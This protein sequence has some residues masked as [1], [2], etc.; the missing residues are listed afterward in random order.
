MAKLNK[1]HKAKNSRLREHKDAVKNEEGGLAFKFE[2]A[3]QE[4]YNRVLT[5]LVGEPK[6]Y[7]KQDEAIL[8]LIKTVSEDDPE[9]ILQLAAFARNEMYLRS[10]PQV[11]LAEATAYPET[12]KFVRKWTPSIV[13][14]ADEPCEVLAY[15]QNRF[16]HIGSK[17][18][19][20]MLAN[21]LKRGLSDAFKQWDAYQL[22]K[23]DRDGP[24]KMRDV[25]K[26]VHPKPVDREHYK[27]LGMLK[28]RNLPIPKTWETKLSG[29]GASKESWEEILPKMGYMGMLRNLRNFIKHGV[30]E[31]MYLPRLT[32]AD[33]VRKSKQLPFRFYSAY[34]TLKQYIEPDGWDEPK[35]SLDS[36]AVQRALEAVE[37]ALELSVVNMPEIKGSTFM[38]ADNSGSMH[39]RLSAK[40]RVRLCDVANLLQAM[41]HKI[42]EG[43]VATSVFGQDFAP[44][45]VKKTDGV[46]TNMEKFRNK[47]VGHATNAYK[48][49]KWLKGQKKRYDRIIIFSDMQCYSNSGWGF[50]GES[51]AEQFEEYKRKHGDV[52]LYSLDLAGY[53]TAQ[54]PADDGS[55]VELAGWSEKLLQFIDLYE[56]SGADA[57]SEISKYKPRDIRKPKNWF[58]A[59]DGNDKKSDRSD[60]R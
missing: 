56:R 14:R 39:N 27:M 60:T 41:A 1:P 7:G 45:Y 3:K 12:K 34:A 26:V 55:V 51:L 31:D 10:I 17:S 37:T 53:G 25:L 30:D 5:S 35:D 24:W 20:G 58:P 22:A 11:L 33:E 19:K 40:S 28:D 59:G 38:T 9:F 49:L 13:R 54:F 36:F 8:E 29:S 4:L 2:S 50:G 42:C 21:S 57:I 18:K 44:V 43:N 15:Y 52:V 6:F 47:H 23:Y 48:A 16:G 46:L 32:D